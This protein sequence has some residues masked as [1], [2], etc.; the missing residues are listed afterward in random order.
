MWCST[1]PA[2]RHWRQ[3]IDEVAT[4][5]L[6]SRTGWARDEAGRVWLVGHQNWP[7]V[8]RRLPGD[9]HV[10]PEADQHAAGLAVRGHGRPDC[11]VG[12]QA[13][14]GGTQIEPDT[15]RQVEHGAV[16]PDRLPSR[17]RG[18]GVNR[19]TP[20]RIDRGEVTVVAE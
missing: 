7:A 20:L 1:R 14:G 11:T 15:G 13:L 9:R 3:V 16:E 10:A 6:A 8:T 18:R 12:S 5:P 19:L 2:R 17:R 4:A